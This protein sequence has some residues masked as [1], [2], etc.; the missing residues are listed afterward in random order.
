MTVLRT[1]RALL[2]S[3]LR[4][5]VVAPANDV[6]VLVGAEVIEGGGAYLMLGPR[7]SPQGQGQDARTPPRDDSTPLKA[8]LELRDRAL[9]PSLMGLIIECRATCPTSPDLCR[10]APFLRPS[11][12]Q[13]RSDGFRHLLGPCEPQ[14]TPFRTASRDRRANPANARTAKTLGSRHCRS[15]SIFLKPSDILRRHSASTDNSIPCSTGRIIC[16]THS[17]RCSSNCDLVNS[18]ASR[19]CSTQ[20]VVRC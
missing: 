16:T 4:I 17:S 11:E 2:Q 3:L 14:S 18:L 7:R 13:V 8:R 9:E 5:A 10:P 20:T 1:H 12:K 6:R 15:P 19:R